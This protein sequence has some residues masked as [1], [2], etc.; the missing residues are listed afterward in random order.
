MNGST[1]SQISSGSLSFAITNSSVSA[2]ISFPT[3]TGT[4]GY[5]YGTVS[6]SA[7]AQLQSLFGTAGNRIVGLQFGNTMSLSEGLYWLGIHQRQSSTSANIGLSTA[8]VG[9]AANSVVNAG[10][11]GSSTAAFA[12]NTKYNW[13]WGVFTSTGLAGHSGTNLPTSMALSGISKSV[14]V[15]P[16]ITFIST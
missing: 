9:N 15:L 1:L 4:A 16:L 6:G 2:T 13:G 14:I 8:M 11:W 12:T 7:T 3:A 5:T 10:L